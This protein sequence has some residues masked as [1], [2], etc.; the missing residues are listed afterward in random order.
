VTLCVI[1]GRG[2]Y[3]IAVTAGLDPAVHHLSEKMDCRV[4]PGNDKHFT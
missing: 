3:F 2:F 4:K 1:A